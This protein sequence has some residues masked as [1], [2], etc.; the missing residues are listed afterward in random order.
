MKHSR[1][2]TGLRVQ[3]MHIDVEDQKMLAYTTIDT[4]NSN[5]VD[6]SPGVS[7]FRAVRTPKT[8]ISRGAQP[9]DQQ[10][11]DIPG[12]ESIKEP[13]LHQSGVVFGDQRDQ[14]LSVYAKT[15]EI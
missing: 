13:L 6:I 2:V 7:L 14:L 9:Q 3:G 4:S 11:D 8:A 1:V 12:E 10:I 15:V 5:R